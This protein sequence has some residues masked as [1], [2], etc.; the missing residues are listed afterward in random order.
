MELI[1]AALLL[2]KSGKKIEESAIKKILEAAEIK[3]EDAKIKA[4]IAA[5]DGVDIEKAIKE[6]APVATTAPQAEAK[7]SKEEKKEEEKNDEKSEE[8]AAAGLG[9]LFG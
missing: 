4:L 3:V 9:S 8:S 6:A 1:Y 2:H 5:L 7:E